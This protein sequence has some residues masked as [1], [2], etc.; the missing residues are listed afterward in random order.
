MTEP[1]PLGGA[2]NKLRDAIAEFQPPPCHP[3]TISPWV[4]MSLLQKAIRR[5]RKDLA[6]RAAATLLQGSPERLW[7]RLGCIA[8]EDVGMADLDTVA[9]VTA[10]LAGKRC[11]EELGGEWRVASYTVSR[12]ADARKCRATDDL[13]LAAENHPDFEDTRLAFAFRRTDDLI[14]IVT[15]ADPLPIRALAA[16]YAIGTDR[17]PSGLSSR[18]GEAEEVF[19]ALRQTR[20][21]AAVV[22]IAREGFRRTG[23]VLCPFVAL[24]WP[25][26]Q[27]E[28]AT[29]EDDDYPPEVML[30]EV[31]G[32][33]YDIYSREGRAALANFIETRTE[34]A[35]W[36]RDHIPPRQR[37]AFLGGIVFRV[38]GGLVRSRLRWETG[39]QLRRMVDMECNGS[40][41]PDGTEIL[42]LMKADIPALNGVRFRLNGGSI[43]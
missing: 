25:F 30:G 15:G 12:M 19:N 2:R 20:I 10:A 28:T 21:P 39:D 5:G 43:R 16:W 3:L 8:F 29:V 37:I 11:R 7:R 18:Q 33:A 4:A 17:R 36:V 40:H 41:C 9:V 38:E 1:D 26:R 35:R 22:E 6:L 24:L 31:P 14:R 23:E 27:G 13:L 32:C 42:Q 34:T